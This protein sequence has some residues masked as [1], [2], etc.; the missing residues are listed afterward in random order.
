MKHSK[1][2]I[3]MIT[4]FRDENFFLS[5]M[6]PCN[7][8]YLGIKYPSSENA[9]QS[10]KYVDHNVKLEIAGMNPYESKRYSREH[11][12]TNMQFD[13]TKIVYMRNILKL[14]FDIPSLRRMLVDT[15]PHELIEGNHWRDTFWGQCPLGNGKNHLGTIL[16]DI[17]D[18]HMRGCI[19][20]K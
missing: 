3:E 6:Y 19:Y 20:E 11:E 16:M 17:R 9:Y 8:E 12:M 15:Y 5:N 4:S 18:Q 1:K 2:M 13:D 14:K 10:T 7:I